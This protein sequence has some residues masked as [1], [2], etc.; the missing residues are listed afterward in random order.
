MKEA[1]MMNRLM[2]CG[3]LLSALSFFSP[4]EAQTA[5]QNLDE[6]RALQGWVF[7]PDLTKA[8]GLPDLDGTP[9]S[10][11]GGAAL[12]AATFDPAAFDARDYAID[13]QTNPDLPTSFRIGNVGVI[14]FHSENR[15][16]VLFERAKLNQAK[17]H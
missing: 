5:P 8:E 17:P 2:A 13:L 9:S 4:A 16:R 11:E 6:F 3:L 12:D 1:K 14:Q 7:S 10:L 15:C